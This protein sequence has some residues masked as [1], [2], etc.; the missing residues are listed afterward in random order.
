MMQPNTVASYLLLIY[1]NA[2]VRSSR[3][4]CLMRNVHPL[5]DN[6]LPVSIA[7]PEADL[8]VCVMDK[9]GDV[10]ELVFPVHR[11]GID[12]VDAVTKKRIEVA[13]THWRKWN[14]N[15]LD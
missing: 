8:E 5:P 7:P 13:P 1:V 15:R 14:E 9:R 6:W 10:V 3:N 2:V 11:R 12:W 4:S